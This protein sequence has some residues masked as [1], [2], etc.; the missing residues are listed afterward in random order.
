MRF[1]KKQSWERKR[2]V[3]L[4]RDEYL[5]QECKRYGRSASANTV[6]HIYPLEEYPHLAFVSD[7]LISLCAVCHERMHDRQTGE[8]TERGQQWM[9][10]RS[11]LVTQRYPPSDLKSANAVRDRRGVNLFQ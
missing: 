7:N 6:H 2:A 11:H 1:Y 4:R 5:C 10:R 3:I 8:L 9:R